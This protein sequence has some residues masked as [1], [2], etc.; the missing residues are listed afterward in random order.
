MNNTTHIRT[1]IQRGRN[2]LSHYL[3]LLANGNLTRFTSDSRSE[4]F[5]VLDSVEMVCNKLDELEARIF[6]LE[7]STISVANR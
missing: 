7:Q 3:E 6:K 4:I 5:D 2:I 1:E